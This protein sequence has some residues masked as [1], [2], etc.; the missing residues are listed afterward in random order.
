VSKEKSA[1]DAWR[2]AAAQT[3]PGSAFEFVWY[4]LEELWTGRLGEAAARLDTEY[5]SRDLAE[6][7]L[8]FLRDEPGWGVSGRPRVT[9]EGDE[10]VVLVRAGVADEPKLIDKPTVLPAAKFT[11]RYRPDGWRLVCIEADH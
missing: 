8:A 1:A 2:E 7:D 6:L 4:F 11:V 10:I 9:D 5:E 3:A